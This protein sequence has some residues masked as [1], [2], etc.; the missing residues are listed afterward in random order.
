MPAFD[1]GLLTVSLPQ[2]LCK[3][4]QDWARRLIEDATYYQWK[5][6]NTDGNTSS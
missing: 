2:L 1:V 3:W 4:L 5:S 6:V